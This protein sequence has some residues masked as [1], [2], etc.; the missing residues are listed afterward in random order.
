MKKKVTKNILGIDWWSKYIWTAYWNSSANIVMP[1]WYLQNDPSLFFNLGDIISRYNIGSIV[2]GLP[3]DKKVKSQ[4]EEFIKWL[5]FVA[6]EIPVEI[7][8]EEYSSVEADA[9]KLHMQKDHMT[10][11]LAAMVILQRYLKRFDWLSNWN[12]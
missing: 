4:V 3:K 6:G 10:D 9:Q 12:V 7:E 5:K 1:I 2:V 11:T 8:D